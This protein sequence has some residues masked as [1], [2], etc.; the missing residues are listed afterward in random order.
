MSPQRKVG[1]ANLR[2]LCLELV[3][4]KLARLKEPGWGP[5]LHLFQTCSH[6]RYN[7]MSLHGDHRE[8]CPTQKVEKKTKAGMHGNVPKLS[9]LGSMC[10]CFSA[11]E[12]GVL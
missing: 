2:L 12:D 7:L 8:G 3:H 4:Y 11:D 5:P 9:L 1:Y 6:M 10:V